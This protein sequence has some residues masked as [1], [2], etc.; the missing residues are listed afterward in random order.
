MPTNANKLTSI[1]SIIVI[2]KTLVLTRYLN[3]WVEETSIASICSVTFMEPNSAPILDPTFPE[4]TRAVSN[5]AR[6]RI[7]AM[8]IREGSQED[9]PKEEREGRDCLVNT[10]PVIKAV[11]DIIGIDLHPIS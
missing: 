9:A 3:G 5:G 11:S 2:A 8:P 10:I 1:G 7:M 6:A 4:I